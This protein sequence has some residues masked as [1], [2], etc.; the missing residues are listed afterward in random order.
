MP[1]LD[2]AGAR[3]GAAAEYDKIFASLGADELQL[4]D[5]NA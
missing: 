2:T 3:G 5:K 4:G 1:V